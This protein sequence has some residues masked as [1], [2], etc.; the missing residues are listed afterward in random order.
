MTIGPAAVTPPRRSAGIGYDDASK[1]GGWG[2]LIGAQ[3]RV[4][5]VNPG[6]SHLVSAAGRARRIILAACLAMSTIGQS[7]PSAAQA[8]ETTLTPEQLEILRNLPEEERDA[9]IESVLGTGYPA[10]TSTRD[11]R[12]QFP[13]TV[14]P[15]HPMQARPERPQEPDDLRF[16]PEDTLLLSLEVRE[17]EGPEP[18]EPAPAESATQ[19]TLVPEVPIPPAAQRRERI[20]RSPA[21][22]DRLQRL[23][24]SIQGRNPY[25]LD[26]LG[27]LELGA[28]GVIA[29][30][31]LNEEQAEQRLAA[32]RMLK[33]FEVD[34]IRLPLERVGE[35][36][37]EPFGYDLFAGSPSTFA[38]ATDIPVPVDYIVG[39]G[40]GIRVQLYGAVNQSYLLTVERN[41]NVNFPQIGPVDVAG[42]TFS[43]M[44]EGLE[45]RVARQLIGTSASISMGETRAIRVFVLGE[46]YRP[47]SYTVSGLS[48]ITNAL[49]VSGGVTRI[50]SLRRIQLK[51]KGQI[52]RELDL[53]DLLLHGDTSGD[54][55]L[56]PGDVIFIPPVGRTVSI[57]G[58]VRR[59]AIYELKGEASPGQ[60]VALAGGLTPQADPSMARVER[61]DD[62][63]RTVTFDVD[64]AQSRPGGGVAVADG[65]VLRVMPIRPTLENS[66]VLEGHV[67]RPGARQYRPGMRLSDV[68]ESLDELRPHADSRY[69][70]IRRE[71]KPDKSVSAISADLALALESPGSEEDIAVMPRDRIYVFDQESG[72]ERTVARLLEELRL[73]AR[74]DRP[75]QVVGIGGRVRAAGQY[76]LEP[77]M[78]VSDLIRAGGSLEDAAYGGQAELTR[79]RVV[80]GE[81]RSSELLVVDIGAVIRGDPSA[82]I[83]LE[84]YDFLNVKELPQWSRQESVEI[85]GE[86]R[87]PGTYPLRRGE[88]LHSVLQRAG[89]TT[90]LAFPEGSIFLREDLKHKEEERLEQLANRLQRDIAA[91]ALQATQENSQAS[92]ALTIGQ[93]LL[94]DLRTTKAVGRLVFSLEDVA[95]NPAGSQWDIELKDGDRILIPRRAQEVS[96]LGEVQ[97]LTSHMYRPDLERD[98]YI[99]LSGGTTQRADRGRTYVVRADG[100]VV[101][102]GSGW[103][104]RDGQEIRPGDSIVVPL[105]AES[106]RPL[107]LWVAVTQIVYQLAIAAAAVNSF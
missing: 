67:Y 99:E 77:G 90:D 26:K 63:R 49:F 82:D 38:P 98:D 65:D 19:P 28:V 36:A 35:E 100:S 1:K 44:R 59:P 53:Y 66:V 23:R 92:Q 84:P 6:A 80:N 78:R 103:F 52:V 72:R 22:L 48:T 87:F 57:A 62:N 3:D 42:Q 37:L 43:Q 85:E 73:Q 47:G 104:A 29:L 83:Q 74:I 69:V 55:R 27:R 94:S 107:P 21:E 88:T 51:R 7:A 12:L 93:S 25:R 45:E 5:E 64:L 10:G 17:F 24:E 106:M 89:G 54:S 102:A 2:G 13:E 75:M 58:E 14:F 56:L 39:P 11:K 79:H 15:R 32:E 68:F 95:A 96:V 9:L 30:A 46:A 101:T 76:P 71:S 4:L 18:A 61:I 70:L 105:D 60:L 81:S 16:K 86:V 31:G 40:D 20:L 33:D 41:G 50:G 97:T 8:P 91:L 34:I